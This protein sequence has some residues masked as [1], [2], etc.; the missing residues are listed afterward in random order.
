M[1]CTPSHAVAVQGPVLGLSL[2]LFRVEAVRDVATRASGIRGAI[3]VYKIT[4]HFLLVSLGSP[5]R[6]ASGTDMRPPGM[7]TP[8]R[9]MGE[10][11]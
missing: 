4:M 7:E 11:D 10:R 2:A 9:L 8:G 3:D 6:E 5:T 1:S